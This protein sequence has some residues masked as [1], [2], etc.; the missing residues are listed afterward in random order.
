MNERAEAILDY[1]FEGF[2]DK[3]KADQSKNPFRKWFMGG[4]AVDR[5]ICDQF[6][7]DLK[8]AIDG[9]YED[10]TDDPESCLALIILL[11]QFTRNVFRNDPRAFDCDPKAQSI[12]LDAIDKGLDQRLSLVKRVFLYMPLMHAEDID[13]QNKSVAL[14]EQ[15]VKDSKEISPQNTFVYN[16]NL[17]YAIIHRNDIEKYGRFPYRNAVLGRDNTSEEEEFLAARSK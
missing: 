13:I 8:K 9:Q 6:G 1:W 11:D 17:K 16:G 4:E 5:E 12:V 7:D 10:W 14:F 3:D 2:E 15:L